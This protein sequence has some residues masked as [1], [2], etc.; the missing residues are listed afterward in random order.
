MSSEEEDEVQRRNKEVDKAALVSATNFKKLIEKQEKVEAVLASTFGIKTPTEKEEVAVVVAAA[1]SEEN[2]FK[3]P[4]TDLSYDAC[5]PSY[6][7]NEKEEDY[8]KVDDEDDEDAVSID[9]IVSPH[10]HHE[11]KQP[12]L[13][14]VIAPVHT[15]P[16]QFPY[17]ERNLC[18]KSSAMVE[19]VKVVKYGGGGDDN[20]ILQTSTKRKCPPDDEHGAQVKRCK[21]DECTNQV[22]RNG[23]CARHEAYSENNQGGGNHSNAAT[24]TAT[25][26][27]YSNNFPR[28]SGQGIGMP[29]NHNFRQSTNVQSHRTNAMIIMETKNSSRQ[30]KIA[31]AEERLR[32]NRERNCLILSNLASQ[33]AELAKIEKEISKL[34]RERAR[35]EL[36]RRKFEAALEDV[37]K[38]EEQI[39]NELA[40]LN[41]LTEDSSRKDV[42]NIR[43][44]TPISPYGAKESTLTNALGQKPAGISGSEID[45]APPPAPYK[46]RPTPL[47]A[48]NI[49][50]S[51][52]PVQSKALQSYIAMYNEAVQKHKKDTFK[53]LK[54]GAARGEKSVSVA[55]IGEARKVNVAVM[56]RANANILKHSGKQFCKE[57]EVTAA[58]SRAE[59]EAVQLYI[60]EAQKKKNEV[61]ASKEST[62]AEVAASPTYNVEMDHINQGIKE[63]TK[64]DSD[65]ISD[66]HDS[67]SSGDE[68]RP[69][70]RSGARKPSND[71]IS[72]KD[73]GSSDNHTTKM[74]AND[75][76]ASPNGVEQLISTCEN[77]ENTQTKSKLPS[78]SWDQK[79]KV[80]KDHIVAR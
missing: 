66:E 45:A 7:E 53:L 29:M 32:D 55:A 49:W 33:T 42:K 74:M 20:P 18:T 15:S 75:G 61:A 3:W 24:A 46:P 27:I 4:T 39:R 22:K 70:A 40:H 14:E 21:V 10:L 80:V 65:S 48:K 68:Q 26:D 31:V 11:K 56:R 54:Q 12:S 38:E 57:Q 62:E 5:F 47:K 43:R 19:E 73:G 34:E 71:N 16:I 2:T 1:A 23:L 9:V 51:I 17:Q 44:S 6:S 36:K 77:I 69:P 50:N 59:A 25:S 52:L 60:A 64:S 35:K 30:K 13:F 63:E 78:L 37:K 76:T 41:S 28:G 67:D 8:D 79:Y 58:L 72:S